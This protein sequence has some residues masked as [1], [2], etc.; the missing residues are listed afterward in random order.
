MANVNNPHSFLWERTDNSGAVRLK[1]RVTQSNTTL[2]V[3]DP[4]VLASGLLK[5]AGVTSTALYGFAAEAVTGAA[6][7]RKSVAII[8]AVAGYTFSAQVKSSTN[9]TAGYLGARGGIAGTTAGK[10]G[11]SATA[12]T[13]VLQVQGIRRV[14]GNAWGTY[15]QLMLTVIRSSYDGS[16]R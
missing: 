2:G 1:R 4:V 11:F 7:V 14:P 3:G 9:L 5:L 12:T 13:S 10:I 6:G 15:A 8:P 16:I